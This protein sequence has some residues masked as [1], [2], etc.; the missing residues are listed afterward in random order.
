MTKTTCEIGRTH[1]C[2]WKNL[3]FKNAF[4]NMLELDLGK[5]AY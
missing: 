1:K 4:E 3:N 5:E 2:T